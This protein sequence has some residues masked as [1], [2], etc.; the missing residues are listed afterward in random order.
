MVSLDRLRAPGIVFL[1]YLFL[2]ATPLFP[3]DV[4]IV[5]LLPCFDGV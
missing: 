2:Q 3:H 4:T 1:H 5:C